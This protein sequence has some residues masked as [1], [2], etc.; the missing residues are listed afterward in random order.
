M[1]TIVYVG[2]SLDGFIAGEGGDISWLTAF[3][4]KEI[5]DSYN[6]FM[7]EID[8]I[9]IGRGT[10]ETVI[11]FSTWPYEKKVFLLSTSIKQVPEKLKDKLGILSMNPAEVRK[12]LS[13]NGFHSVYV[14]GGK[15]IQGFLREDCIDEIIITRLPVLLGGGI[16]LFG[17]LRDMLEFT[18]IRTDVYSNGLVKSHYI[19]KRN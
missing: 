10:Y 14:D 11:S 16:P 2:V 9:V 17:S 12:Y 15:V 18:H 4:N 3:E 6:N 13:D 5:N 1:R 8:A 19:R 7:A